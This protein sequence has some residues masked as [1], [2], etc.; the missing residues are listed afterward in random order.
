MRTEGIPALLAAWRV[1]ATGDV[2]TDPHFL[3]GYGEDRIVKG[4]GAGGGEAGRPHVGQ[5]K[6]VIH[7][8]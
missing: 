1:C 8:E 3:L 6:D 7:K 5:V 4:W 2:M